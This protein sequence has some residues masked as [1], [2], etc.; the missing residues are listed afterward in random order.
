MIRRLGL[1]PILV[2][3]AVVVGGARWLWL[4]MSTAELAAIGVM[5]SALLVGVVTWR[6]RR[7]R[8][9]A[10]YEYDHRTLGGRVYIGISHNPHIRARQHHRD[11]DWY[12]QST[13]RMRVVRWYPSEAKARLA[14]RS[15]IRR[16]WAAGEPLENRVHVPR[17]PARQPNGLRWSP[18]AP[19]R[20]P[21]IRVRAT[22]GAPV[23]DAARR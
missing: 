10:L 22:V 7:R 20:R 18:A 9:T 21:P 1:W 4:A 8:R 13:G 11:S 15:T 19:R 17:A 14:E 6:V 16:A 2:L 5:G 23:R 3:G 12:A